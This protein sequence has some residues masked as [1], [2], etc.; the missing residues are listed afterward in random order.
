MILNSSI[1]EAYS[2]RFMDSRFKPHGHY[3]TSGLE[4]KG[5]GCDCDNYELNV[6]V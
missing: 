4:L 5:W 3:D 1:T 2:C 6:S